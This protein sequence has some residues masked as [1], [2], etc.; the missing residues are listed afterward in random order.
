MALAVAVPAISLFVLTAT[1][2]LARLGLEIS[3]DQSV[4]AAARTFGSDE[5]RSHVVILRKEMNVDR[6][7]H[8]H[9]TRRMFLPVTIRISIRRS[10]AEIVNVR[11]KVEMQC[12]IRP[13]HTAPP[14]IHHYRGVD[15][16]PLR[17]VKGDRNLIRRQ[18][19]FVNQNNFTL[20]D[21]VVVPDGKVKAPEAI[22]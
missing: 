19:A 2:A 16:R 4:V 9:V 13:T 8:F 3:G 12:D 14:Q 15:A 10:L 11:R 5:L 17:D 21:L 22:T 6:I 20:G 7:D 1:L 18:C